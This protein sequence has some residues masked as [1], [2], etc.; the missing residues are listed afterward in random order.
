MGNLAAFIL[1]NY[2]QI[3][4]ILDELPIA[5]AALQSGKARED[6]DYHQH[7]ETERQYLAARRKE[8]DDDAEACDYVERLIKYQA[9]RLA[10]T[11]RISDVLLMVFRKLFDECAKQDANPSKKNSQL[12]DQAH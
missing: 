4:Q 3:Q 2:K 1:G 11:C 9:A 8:S 12:R 6:T 5:I 10:C 7:L